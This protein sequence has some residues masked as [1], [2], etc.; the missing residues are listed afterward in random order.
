MPILQCGG[1]TK[2]HYKQMVL[3]DEKDIAIQWECPPCG[4]RKEDFEPPQQ[5]V[6]RIPKKKISR[7]AVPAP[8]M[9]ATPNLAL[10]MQGLANQNGSATNGARKP[11]IPH[12]PK[13]PELVIRDLPFYPVKATL[14]RP[15][16][17]VAS[18]S[19]EQQQQS[20][21]FYLSPE[22]AITV[23]NG[24]KVETN[25]MVVYKM[26]ILLRFTK[27]ASDN[28]QDDD[29]P[30]N[31]CLKVN[32]KVCPLPN[33]KPVPANRPNLEAKRPP[34]PLIITSL[35][36]L[37]TKSCL[38]QVS[39][40]YALAKDGTKHTVSVYLVEKLTPADL[41]KVMKTKGQRDPSVTKHVICSKLEDKDDEISTTSCKVSMACPLGMARMSLP[42]RAS[43]CDHLQCFDADL[44]LKMN[45]KKPKWVCPVCNK[46][47]YFEHLFLDGFYIQ[48]LVSP[49][50]RALTTNDIILNN[51]ASWEPVEEEV[52]GVSDSEDEEEQRAQAALRLAQAAR[53]PVTLDDDDDISV[54]PITGQ[55]DKDGAPLLYAPATT[56]ARP[57]PPRPPQA[58]PEDDDDVLV[59]RSYPPETD[60]MDFNFSVKFFQFCRDPPPPPRATTPP[61]GEVAGEVTEGV[62]DSGS[63]RTASS[64]ESAARGRGRGGKAS[65]G[66]KRAAAYLVPASSED[67]AAEPPTKVVNGGAKAKAPKKAAAP[68]KKPPAKSNRR[69]RKVS[70]DEGEGDR[71]GSEAEAPP[72]PRVSSRP[73]RN[74]RK[75]TN[76]AA[77]EEAGDVL[78]YFLDGR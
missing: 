10:G 67:E 11:Y 75:I 2:E 66:A 40:S 69:K 28:V 23:N 72:P 38:N 13:T 39:V 18:G 68:R 62:S 78:D 21:A 48:L 60:F 73:A 74:S 64:K 16:P 45:E 24:R 7:D 51:D 15:T 43:T 44:Y 70:S 17:L 22:Q 46:P 8:S 61:A 27:P 53:E 32:N 1:V 14:L 41:L 33:P 77:L 37:N 35:C 56:S 4:K 55:V 50:F 25:G 65:G 76:Y 19:A 57:P 29:F 6:E 3:A 59:E 58:A 49:Q 30:R 71:S 26:H 12:T 20:L 52:E 42:C 36:K 31:L 34:K 47:A 5:T 54:L 9:P 63:S